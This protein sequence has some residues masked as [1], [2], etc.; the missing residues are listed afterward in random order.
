VDKSDS[1]RIHKRGEFN[2]GL[3][4]KVTDK[5]EFKAQ[6]TAA[7]LM[8]IEALEKELAPS[9]EPVM[10]GNEWYTI[11]SFDMSN[12]IEF[13]KFQTEYREILKAN[14]KITFEELLQGEDS[15]VKR[16]ILFLGIDIEPEE[17][18]YKQFKYLMW[19]ISKQYLFTTGDDQDY[20]NQ[21]TPFFFV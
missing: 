9:S 19:V 12:N 18:T 15:I 8:K 17:I 2:M 7:Q 16:I 3:I 20:I 21:M 4:K 5:D 10:L 13:S 11:D 14:P 1:G 6:M